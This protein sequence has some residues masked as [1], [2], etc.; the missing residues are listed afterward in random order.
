MTNEK[1]LRSELVKVGANTAEAARWL[2]IT[3]QAFLSK[4]QNVREFKASEIYTLR[5]KLNLSMTKQDQIFF[6]KDVECKSTGNV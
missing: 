4:I 3:Q 2:G 5:K 6:A 1:L